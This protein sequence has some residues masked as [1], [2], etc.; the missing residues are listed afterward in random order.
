MS[1]VA[2][3]YSVDAQPRIKQ[4][5]E[6]ELSRTRKVA[7]LRLVVA[8]YIEILLSAGEDDL[9]GALQFQM[10]QVVLD[11]MMPRF[12]Y[13]QKSVAKR[14]DMHRTTLRNKLKKHGYIHASAM[15]PVNSALVEID[16]PIFKP[17]DR[18]AFHGGMS[19]SF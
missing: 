8:E 16:A 13:K 19:L 6:S 7:E 10:D 2:Q 5:N 12:S 1:E 3:Q 9:Y 18:R 15:T 4:M 11:F 17:K 14:L